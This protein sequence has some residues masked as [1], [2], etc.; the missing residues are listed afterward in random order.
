MLCL[1][2]GIIIST[3]I[4]FLGG[5]QL[6]KPRR[7]EHSSEPIL[8]IPTV[9]LK[10]EQEA[11]KSILEL[12]DRVALCVAVAVA[13]ILF[14]E[15]RTSGI[16]GVLLAILWGTGLYLFWHVIQSLRWFRKGD[17]KRFR[18]VITM[19]LVTAIWSVAVV[20]YGTMRWPHRKYIVQLIFK[21]SPAW[22]P[23]RRQAVLEKMDD[24][25]IYLRGLGFVASPQI[26]PIGLYKG[27]IV[28]AGGAWGAGVYYQSLNISEEGN[29]QPIWAVT[30]YS[31]WL[32]NGYFDVFNTNNNA[33][34]YNNRATTAI[35]YRCYYPSSFFERSLCAGNPADAQR[36]LDALWDLR[37]KRKKGDVDRLLFYVFSMWNTSPAK[38][39]SFDRFFY[40]KLLAGETVLDSNPTDFENTRNLLAKHG[41][42]AEPN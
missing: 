13:I 18:F 27:P 40:N 29:D 25:Y 33:I 7:A 42:A 12:S 9:D 14:L 30:A 22:T 34:N 3:R 28:T 19:V 6:H 31:S 5:R 36:W 21:E 23:K 10:S 35:I 8:A 32:F 26:P 4:P 17:G 1:G 41:I 11:A 15:D 20:K 24:Y 39:E 38:T 37:S 2:F 16:V